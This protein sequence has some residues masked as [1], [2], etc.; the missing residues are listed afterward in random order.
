MTIGRALLIAAWILLA[1]SPVM[2]GLQMGGGGTASDIDVDTSVGGWT[3][4]DVQGVLEEIQDNL[5]AIAT[6]AG[7]SDEAYDAT[8]WNGVTTI[9]PSKNAVRDKFESLSSVYQPLS[10]NLTSFATVTPS[11]NG[12]SLVSAANYAAM[13]SLLGLVVGTDVQAYDADLTTYAGITPSANVQTFLGASDYSAMRSQLS[14][15][16]GTNVQA[17]DADLSSLASGISGLVKGLGNGSGFTAATPNVDY[18]T[19]TGSGAG[20][21]GITYSQVGAAAASHAHSGSDITSGTVPSARLPLNTDTTAGVVSAGTGYSNKVWKTDASGVPGWRDDTGGSDTLETLAGSATA[22]TIVY[23]NG[24]AWAN[25]APGSSGTYLKTTGSSVTWD[26]PTGAGDMLKSVY[27]TDSDNI[28]DNSETLLT[29]TWAAPGDIGTS[30][31]AAGTFTNL[32]ATGTTTLATSISGVLKAASGVVSGSAGVSDLA[33]STSAA[34]YGV[35]SDETG[36][37]AGALAVFNQNPTLAGATFSAHAVFAT[38]YGISTG[39]SSGNTLVVRGY[40][41]DQ[42]AYDNVITVTAGNTPTVAIATDGNTTVN[43]AT[44]ATG[45]SGTVTF[46]GDTSHVGDIAAADGNSAFT[47]SPDNETGD[48]LV[49]RAYDVD[50]TT[51]DDVLTITSGNTPSLA[52]ATDGNTTINGATFATGSSGDVTLAGALAFGSDPADTGAIRLSN[53]QYIYSEASPAGTDVSV[54]GVTSS[55]VIAIGSAG[56]SGVTITPNTT[57]SGTLSVTGTTTLATS[58]SGILKASSGV[59][60]GSAGI[61]DL[62]SSTSSALAGVISDETGTGALVFGTSP[63][64]TTQITTPKVYYGGNLTV[65][66]Y[67]NS[68]DSTVTISNSSA[69]YVANLVVEGSITSQASSG[70]SYISLSDNASMASP[71]TFGYYF[72][73]SAPTV[74]VNGTSYGLVV[75]PMTTAGDIIIGGTAGS[76]TRLGIGSDGQVLT[77]SSGAITWST[78]SGTGD[79]TG[80]SSSATG[81]LAAYSSTSGK[82]IGRSYVSF[83][84]PATTVKTYTLP[85][86]N[87]TIITE[88]NATGGIVLGDSTPDADGE[89]GYA[90]NA[91]TFYANSEDLSLTA[92]SDTWTLGSSTGVTAI[93]LGSMNLVT[94]GTIELGNASDTTLSRSS[95]G[96]LAVEGVTVSLNSTSATHTAGTI[97]LGNASDTTIA[98]SAAGVITVEGETVAM[99]KA[100]QTG[101]HASPSTTNPLSPTWT[102]SMHYV[103]YGA[104]GTINLP[105]ASDYAGRGII[106]YNTGA[107]TITIDSNGTEVIVRDGTV[108]SGGVSITLSSGAGN[109]VALFC[110]GT[111]WI[112]LGYKGTLSQGS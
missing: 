77:V 81:E 39:T 12:L 49:L 16:V 36:S 82:A 9:A 38:G 23:Y 98:R 102:G 43:G 47:V 5:V 48:T 4:T 70:A 101:T 31:P 69:T 54:I 66:A 28:A 104:T 19:P 108:Q 45:S 24:S 73:N 35:L 41:V 95:A 67:N 97:E 55:Q 51:W 18:L 72:L 10:S 85:N 106:I 109:Y 33:S 30:T 76:P 22:G 100:S 88:G 62:A 50:G 96:V 11:A 21:T 6:T 57:I 14:L 80:G 75:N 99:A 84:G 52:I 112:T 105:A 93:S 111:R 1:V 53:A 13:R 89:L 8:T 90:S 71:P 29:K 25:L 79:V 44:F 2:A 94:T 3:A 20:L 7:V 61:S 59:V 87:A 56:A 34:L 58:L 32:T 68:A 78:P 83:S 110:D 42:A 15:V 65:D 17:Y 63:T 64:F 92:S 74:A 60:S 91:Y 40:D 37:G 86:S 107:Y 27:D 103:W 26:T 46:N